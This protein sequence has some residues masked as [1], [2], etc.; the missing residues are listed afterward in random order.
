MMKQ[1]F[2]NEQQNSLKETKYILDFINELINKV[3]E[4]NERIG[5]V[6]EIEVNNIFFKKI[7]KFTEIYYRNMSKYFVYV[8]INIE[9]YENKLN[10]YEKCNADN[11]DA[12]DDNV[13]FMNDKINMQDIQDYVRQC[14]N[15][16][17]NACIMDMDMEMEMEM[18]MEECVNADAHSV[19]TSDSYSY[20]TTC[21]ISSKK[22]KKRKKSKK[23]NK[24]NKLETTL[25]YTDEAYHRGGC[26]DADEEDM[27]NGGGGGGGGNDC[28][29]NA[30]LSQSSSSLNLNKIKNI[31]RN[32]KVEE[33]KNIRIV[34]IQKK[35]QSIIK[36]VTNNIESEIMKQY[37]NYKLIIDN[38]KK[39][40]NGNK[41]NAFYH[42]ILNN[43]DSGL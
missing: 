29:S 42:L 2:I 34:P 18:E 31:I 4:P 30:A 32:D 11:A 1:Y 24:K 8:T 10:L 22:I 36:K 6:N 21:S 37:I 5:N 9:N 35:I 15:A 16:N 12:R 3:C 19:K 17:A 14:A 25:P 39:K 7:Y 43:I 41:L 28:S 23:D 38:S 26:G 20:S 40:N 33:S 13:N 27:G